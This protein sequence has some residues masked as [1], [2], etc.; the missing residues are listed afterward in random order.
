MKED[1]LHFI[2]QSKILLKQNLLLSNKNPI[3]IISIGTL[4]HDAGPD[5]L[6]LK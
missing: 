2:W 5:F 6:M 1:L 3:E 4:N